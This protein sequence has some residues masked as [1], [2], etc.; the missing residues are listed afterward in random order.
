VRDRIPAG[1][2][3]KA[4]FSVDWPPGANAK[5]F[6]PDDRLALEFTCRMRR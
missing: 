6:L 5:G 2:A 1:T 3:T 4:V